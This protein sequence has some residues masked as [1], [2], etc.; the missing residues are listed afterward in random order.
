MQRRQKNQLSTE[1]RHL[2]LRFLFYSGAQTHTTRRS[3]I[4]LST[5]ARILYQLQTVDSLLCCLSKP[6]R[7]QILFFYKRYRIC[8]SNLEI[9]LE[10]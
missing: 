5:R 7:R 2:D 10:I 3:F 9:T 1:A 8:H 6:Y 4:L